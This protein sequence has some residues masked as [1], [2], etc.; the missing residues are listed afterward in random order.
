MV[1]GSQNRDFLHVN[2]ICEY[3]I[4]NEYFY[5]DNI[6]ELRG[7][8]II[9][10]NQLIDLFKIAYPDKILNVKYNLNNNFGIKYVKEFD[11]IKYVENRNKWNL[12]EYN[13]FNYIQN[14]I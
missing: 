11:T 10:I 3:I 8:E 2:N 14:S 13:L 5:S 4:N 6:I 1:I 9:T 12:T 7:N